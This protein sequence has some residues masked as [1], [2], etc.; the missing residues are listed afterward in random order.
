MLGTL[1][2]AVSGI[3]SPQLGTDE[4]VTWSVGE[5]STGRILAL[6]HNVDAVHAA[7][8]LL[9]HEWMA[10]F[11]DSHTALRMPSALAMSGAAAF[12]A[13]IGGRLFGRRAGLC[14]GMLFA[15]IPVVSRFGQEARSYALVVL[16]AT[17]AT[18]LLL[19]ALD[20]PGSPWRWA[21]YALCLAAVGLLH[22]VALT[23]L[24]GHL[25]L[26]VLRFVRRERS[27]LWG[28]CLAVPAG[29]ACVVPLVLVGR[30]Q[31]SRQLFWLPAPGVGGLVGIWPQVFASALCAGVVITLAALAWKEGRDGLVLCLAV[32]LLPPLVLWAASHGDVSYFRFQYVMFTVPAWAVLAGAGLAAV[33]RPSWRPVAVGLA[34]LAVL[35][36]PDQR[37]MRGTF[38][39][40]V[41][42]GADYAGAARTIEKYYRPGDAVVYVRGAPWMLDQG[43]RYYLRRDLKLPEV[44]LAESAVEKNELYPAHCAQPA[45]CL[46]GEGRIWVVVPGTGPDA[47]DA[48]PV[49]QARA[50]SAKYTTYGTERVSGL[51]VALLQRKPQRTP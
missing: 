18:Y 39:H 12:V 13:L 35:V 16:A 22:L 50:L 45:K 36:L 29:A 9:M 32:A 46:K 21:G 30:S 34:V 14:G 43:V 37:T 33:T 25:A 3:N 40:D 8:Y 7:Y 19:R 28:F 10:V 27:G 23:V 17:L 11:G 49:H 31:A 24:L 15:L 48:V 6:V 2:L 38:Q 5:R 42:H 41:P 4:L 51:T 47:L 44:F 26:V 20:R 1:A